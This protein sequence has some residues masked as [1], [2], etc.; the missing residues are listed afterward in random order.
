M[1]TCMQDFPHGTVA[2]IFRSKRNDADALGYAHAAAEMMKAAEQLPGYVGIWS[3]RGTDGV[4]VTVSYW[5][6]NAAAQAWKN[7]ATHAAIRAQGRERW[8]DWYE[9]VVAEVTRFYNWEK[10]DASEP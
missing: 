10:P 6:D 4:G 9:L 3:A 2:V 7:N 5:K 1:V 8:Y